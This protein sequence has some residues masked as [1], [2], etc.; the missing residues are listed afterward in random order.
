MKAILKK[1][2]GEHKVGTVFSYSG[3]VFTS[4]N[5]TFMAEDVFSDNNHFEIVEHNEWVEFQNDTETLGNINETE[6]KSDVFSF[7]KV[8]LDTSIAS[9]LK[10]YNIN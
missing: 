1:D 3:Y 10:G 6:V 7:E 8:L 2:L 4:G 5:A 9:K